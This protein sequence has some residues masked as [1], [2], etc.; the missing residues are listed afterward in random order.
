MHSTPQGPFRLGA[1]V[2]GD[3]GLVLGEVVAEVPE[4]VEEVRPAE[5]LAVQLHRHLHVLLHQHLVVAVQRVV[6]PVQNQQVPV[7][8]NQQV[9]SANQRRPAWSREGKG[10]PARG[11]QQGARPSA[12]Q[13]G[14]PASRDL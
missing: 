9:P 4:A 6:A 5:L 13:L 3:L 10:T 7:H 2:G 1:V 8:R 12:G 11:G 14:G